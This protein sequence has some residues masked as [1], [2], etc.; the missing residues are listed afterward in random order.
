VTRLL[1]ALA[2]WL[3]THEYIA[4][5]AEGVALVAIFI[6][7]RLDSRA[8]HQQTMEQ[9]EIGQGQIR[10][11]Q[12]QVD[13]SEKQA[14]ASQAMAQSVINSERAWVMADLDWWSSVGTHVVHQTSS[15]E[16]GRAD[17]T[18]ARIKLTCKNEG[19]SPAW[20][21][22]VYAHMEMISSVE[23][24]GP[25]CKR[26][27]GRKF[28]TLGPLGAGK[29]RIR[30]L[31]LECPGYLTGDKYLSV[32]AI[33]EYRDIFDMR[34]ETHLGYSISISSDEIVRQ[35]APPDSNP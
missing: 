2:S 11:A 1:T 31:N 15:Q 26:D 12:I 33:V 7:D 14:A 19:R 10:V 3:S 6:W 4:I 21:D 20:I 27:D 8:Q 18:A 28:G 32:Y 25:P 22:N 16:G 24:L 34:R 17:I 30:V 9:L 23:N 13:T 5:W 29:E 35:D